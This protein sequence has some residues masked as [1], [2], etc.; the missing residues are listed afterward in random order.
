MAPA[1]STRGSSASAIREPD[2]A[3]DR[4][5]YQAFRRTGR[6][7]PIKVVK[8]WVASWDSSDELLRPD[9]SDPA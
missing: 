8:A 4:L 1:S 6:A 3:E 7:V 9:C 2:I 5:R